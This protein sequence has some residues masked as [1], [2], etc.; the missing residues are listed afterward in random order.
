VVVC[1]GDEGDPGA[2]MDRMILESYPSASSGMLIASVAAGARRGVFY[3]RAE[4]PLAV[5]RVRR[6]SRS[7]RRRAFWARNILGSRHAFRAEVREGAG[8]F[9]LRRGDGPARVAGGRRPH[10]ALPPA[11]PGACAG[12]TACPTLINNVETLAMTPWIL[13]HGADAFTAVAPAAAGGTKVFALAG[14]VA[15]AA[16]RG[17]HGRHGA[18]HRG[19]GRRRR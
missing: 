11:L 18:P 15:G 4:Y 2:F 6:P 1:N 7:A 8:A 14:K 5:E 16:H 19:G 13:R 9:V 12:S 3:I 10:A 17:A